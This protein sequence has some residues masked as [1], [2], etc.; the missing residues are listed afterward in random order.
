MDAEIRRDYIKLYLPVKELF[1]ILDKGNPCIYKQMHVYIAAADKAK[2]LISLLRNQRHKVQ[3]EVGRE[4]AD[5]TR[6]TFHF[7]QYVHSGTTFTYLI[8]S[9][10]RIS[11]FFPALGIP[12]KYGNLP[13]QEN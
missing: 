1:E 6:L 9:N 10:A 8:R 3:Y 2:I 5:F 12:T 13:L 7:K 11:T 4:D